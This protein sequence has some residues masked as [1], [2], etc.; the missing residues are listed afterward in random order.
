MVGR[1]RSLI[2]F[3]LL[4]LVVFNA[5]CACAT[6]VPPISETSSTS[7]T[8]TTTE[9]LGPCG[10]DCGDFETPPCTVAVCNTGQEIGPL[11]TCVVVPLPKGTSCDDGLFCTNDDYCD[12]GTCVGGG[13]TSCSIPDSPCAA[14]V[15]YEETKSCDVT[16]VNDGADCTPTDLCEVS[17]VCHLGECVGEPKDCTFS[18]LN[19]C[20]SVG[21]DPATGKCT[22]VPDPSKDDTACVLSGD[23]CSTNKT[24]KAGVCGGGIPKDCS[25]LDVGCE[26]G[27]CDPDNGVCTP[28]PAPIGTSCSEGIH[29]CDV[30][31]CDDKGVCVG[32][33]APNGVACND[34][35]SCTKEDECQIGACSGAPISGCILYLHESFESCPSGWTFGGDWECG[36][37]EDVGPLEAHTGE[38]VIATQVAGVYHVNQSFST[39]VADSP[40]IDLTAATSP[41]LSFWV[42]Q[43]TEGGTFDGWNARISINGGQSFT[44]LT[45][46]TP[47]YA[48]TIANQPAW[49]GDHSAEGWQ[50]YSVDLTAYAGKSVI[51]RFAFRS[52]GATV[53]PG[54][55]ID[56]ITVA[57]PLQDPL[58]IT[59]PS[60]LMDTY[61]DMEYT[62]QIL[63]TGGTG[64]VKWS[65]KDVGLNKDWLTIDEATGLLKGTP[66]DMEVGPVSFTVHVEEALLPSNFADATYT[67]KVNKAA[68]YTSF[69]G[70][71][72]DG[73]TLTGDWEC[74]TPTITGPATAYVGT[75]C[76]ATQI[77]A[78][79]SDLQTFT[80]TT[81]ASP[82]IDLAGLINPKLTFRMWVDTEGT[83]YDGFNL[84]ISTDGGLTYTIV[85][86]AL[87]AYG[88]MI[89][90]KPAWGG[91]QADV[92]WQ[93]VEADLSAYAGLSIR[94]RFAFQSDSSGTFPGVYI[95]DILIN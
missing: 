51:L 4:L 35:D 91:H 14:V 44:T 36:K 33:A 64:N 37:P 8:S 23:P 77:D 1:V 88:L 52:D 15:C 6:G 7:S 11:N 85:N 86:N 65:I 42:W 43:H 18:P 46:V 50:P 28:R 9:D 25:A 87:P 5:G 90:G 22:G 74:G 26:I 16:P 63:K 81:A 66:S 62:K 59:T 58:Y 40:P 45:T 49:G 57:E 31:A 20:N 38:N 34:H 78:D 56:D 17:G 2:W 12:N 68:Y 79:Y 67:F 13:E 89:A 61:V 95:D 54:V 75:Q 41:V 73:W 71:C 21:C 84:Q 3:W 92:G 94:L 72:P 93:P 32:S 39:T 55:Y 60:P 30:G 29:E 27:L 24:C 80:A 53:F 69:E 10:M 83:T 70:T 47:A 76:L 48:Y 82:S 19:E